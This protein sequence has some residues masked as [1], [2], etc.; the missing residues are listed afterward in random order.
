MKIYLK[1][2]RMQMI[3]YS[4]SQNLFNYRGI[5]II[6]L[7]I[8]ET[9]ANI[10]MTKFQNF[11]VLFLKMYFFDTIKHEILHYRHIMIYQYP[12]SQE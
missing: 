9:L 11:F 3:F 6:F 12:Q 7:P 8:Y 1:L 10:T 5:I 2:A 4:L